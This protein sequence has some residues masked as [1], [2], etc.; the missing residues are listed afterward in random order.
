MLQIRSLRCEAGSRRPEE[1]RS[2]VQGLKPDI[3]QLKLSGGMLTAT[4]HPRFTG[5]NVCR[6]KLQH[7]TNI[8]RPM[9]PTY[10]FGLH[11][12]AKFNA[13]WLLSGKPDPEPKLGVGHTATMRRSAST[14][15]Y[16]T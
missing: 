8:P 16:L 3:S 2:E 11:R 6:N 4:S 10:M 13:S 15:A 1:P 14:T 5:R 7:T 12:S 9:C